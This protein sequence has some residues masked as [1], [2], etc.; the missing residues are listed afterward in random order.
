MG[1]FSNVVLLDRAAKVALS[2][3]VSSPLNPENLSRNWLTCF[4]RTSLSIF[5]VWNS[6]ERFMNCPIPL[7]EK[8]L[9]AL[10]LQAQGNHI[11]QRL[12]ILML[13]G[14]RTLPGIPICSLMDTRVR[15]VWF[16][17]TFMAGANIAYYCEYLTNIQYELTQKEA[18]LC[19]LMT[20]S[21][22]RVIQRSGSGIQGSKTSTP[23]SEG[24]ENLSISP[25][26]TKFEC[27]KNCYLDYHGERSPMGC[28]VDMTYEHWE[29]H[30]R[31]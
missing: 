28:P 27:S 15:S 1:S 2:I 4:Q 13:I 23:F 14:F 10:D 11:L 3:L 22:L 31:C 6:Y 19:L 24:L 30:G 20:Q 26:S 18:P 9:C 5:E 16:S 8:Q 21:S 7:T 12:T 29:F 17:M 25:R